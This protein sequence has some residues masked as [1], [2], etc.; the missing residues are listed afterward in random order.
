MRGNFYS[1]RLGPRTVRHAPRIERDKEQQ[2]WLG[3][4]RRYS[5]FPRHTASSRRRPRRP[6]KVSQR[7]GHR[8]FA[9][10]AAALGTLRTSASGQTPNAHTLPGTVEPFRSPLPSTDQQLD[11]LTSQVRLNFTIPNYDY[12][13]S[14]LFGRHTKTTRDQSPSPRL[15]DD[16]FV[17]VSV[18]S[19]HAV[20]HL[21]GAARPSCEPQ[22]PRHRAVRARLDVTYAIS[23]C[24]PR[25]TGQGPGRGRPRRT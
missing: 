9:R 23:G 16:P 10:P 7:T 4:G 11:F 25:R 2:K 6:P 19:Q 18:M 13:P 14:P 21:G 5:S 1:A 15:L 24:P 20:P 8:R 22:A 12:S 17:S 3:S